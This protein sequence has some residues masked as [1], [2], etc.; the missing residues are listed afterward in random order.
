MDKILVDIKEIAQVL[1]LKPP[2][3]RKWIKTASFPHIKLGSKA[4]RFKLEDVQQWV[5]QHQEHSAL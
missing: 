2:T 3:I 5:N 1:S 4:L